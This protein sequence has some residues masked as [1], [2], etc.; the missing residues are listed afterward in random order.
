MKFD[1]TGVS[2]PTDWWAP[3]VQRSST[4]AI[5]R[6]SVHVM[7]YGPAE[8]DRN[9]NKERALYPRSQTLTIVFY[10]SKRGNEQQNLHAASVQSAGIRVLQQ[11]DIA[12][13]SSVFFHRFAA[14]CRC[15][16]CTFQWVIWLWW[17]SLW[18]HCDGGLLWQ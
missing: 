3:P 11:K 14:N 10:F 4:N 8:G 15:R 12:I 1:T 6:N 9:E 16:E 18:T 13:R 17:F 2:P 7:G 5:G